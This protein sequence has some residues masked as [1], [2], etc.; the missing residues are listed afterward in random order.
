[1]STYTQIYY[2]IVFSTKNRERV[3][4]AGRRDEL[5]RYIAG[6]I[7]K[8]DCHAYCAGGY[9]DHVHILTHV[10]P[11]LALADLVK[12]IKVASSSWISKE[13]VFPNFT[14]WQDGYAAFTVSHAEKDRVVEYIQDQ[15][16]HHRRFSFHEELRRFL[17]EHRV[18]FD[19]R[20]LI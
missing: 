7:R 20:Y 14:H 12:D 11:T 15:P 17:L 5:F 8:H 6:V 9:E 4:S 1:M 3:L 13:K 10:R 19:E 16:E 2:H 18:E